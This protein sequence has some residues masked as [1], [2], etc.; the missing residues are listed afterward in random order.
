MQIMRPVIFAT[1]FAPGFCWA[2]DAI[3]TSETNAIRELTKS[4]AE[5]G[6]DNHGHAVSLTWEVGT[7]GS[8]G[9]KDLKQVALLPRLRELWLEHTSVTDAGLGNLKGMTQLEV[10]GLICK[11]RR[12]HPS[13][14]TSQGLKHFK[15][16]KNLRV[17][18]L[19]DSDVDDRGLLHLG[20]LANLEDLDLFGTEISDAGL[21]H[22]RGLKKLKYLNISET[23]WEKKG[24]A[25]SPE[26]ART[27]QQY[28]P[29]CDIDY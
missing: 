6:L 19:E 14:V 26:A 4:G 24:G 1:L 11:Y 16:L 12:G 9:D 2:D 21:V 10:L 5:I 25:I 18:R 23:Q 28:L 7:T 29:S 20:A 13:P 3:S 22:L 15:G 17:L 8:F 27:L